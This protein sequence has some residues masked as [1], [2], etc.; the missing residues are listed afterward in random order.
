M[1]TYS[2]NLQ[3]LMMAVKANVDVT[4]LVNAQ[5][6]DCLNIVEVSPRPSPSGEG[7]G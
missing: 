2:K 3:G 4:Q 6:T 5:I 1:A 7:L